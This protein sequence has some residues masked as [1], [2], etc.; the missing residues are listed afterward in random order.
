MSLVNS[1]KRRS[2]VASIKKRTLGISTLREESMGLDKIRIEG[3][4]SIKAL[5]LE[6]RSLN[7]LIG[8]NGAGKSNFLSAFKL[9]NA[10]A[11][12]NL[13]LFTAVGGGPDSFLYFGRKV[14]DKIKFELFFEQYGYQVAL[15]PIVENRLIFE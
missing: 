6:L 3:F 14:T 2:E 12:G 13:Q 10:I 1:R 15:M 9:V 5:D 4:K 7:V 8:A 11:K